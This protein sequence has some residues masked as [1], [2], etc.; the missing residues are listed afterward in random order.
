M[1]SQTQLVFHYKFR[2]HIKMIVKY[3]LYDTKNVRTQDEVVIQKFRSQRVSIS[4]E[5]CHVIYI[6]I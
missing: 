2:K 3:T 5:I 4:I 1:K 6:Y